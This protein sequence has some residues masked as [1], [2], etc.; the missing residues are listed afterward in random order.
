MRASLACIM[1]I[2]LRNAGGSG[3]DKWTCAAGMAAF[4]D[5]G[6]LRVLS[7]GMCSLAEQQCRTS[8][9]SPGCLSDAWRPV[10]TVDCSA[11]PEWAGCARYA[12]EMRST[13]A[14]ALVSQFSAYVCG[15]VLGCCPMAS[16]TLHLSIEDGLFG[17]S[18]PLRRLP[19]AACAAPHGAR[20]ST[21]AACAR[22]TSI[23]IDA[24]ETR[25]I[26]RAAAIAASAP[27]APYSVQPKSPVERCM[28]IASVVTAAADRLVPAMQDAV[29]ACSGCCNA[30]GGE[31]AEDTAAL[32]SVPDKMKP[33]A[34]VCLF[35]L[36]E[37]DAWRDV[38]IDGDID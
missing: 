15:S 29:C 2:F 20:A 28:Y 9:C 5:C 26:P 35:D 4:C 37:E 12:A 7:P 30:D 23:R 8:F 34:R 31:E 1:A 22:V 36:R 24:D 3:Q 10:V 21:C 11:A 32:A 13:G 19:M 17:D 38:D 27:A 14:A 6:S 25:C 33:R 16:P 18:Y